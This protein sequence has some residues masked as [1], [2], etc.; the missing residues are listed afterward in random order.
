MLGTI[1]SAKDG[2]QKTMAINIGGSEQIVTG[3]AGSGWL[4]RSRVRRPA[5]CFSCAPVARSSHVARLRHRPQGSVISGR[6]AR[7]R[8]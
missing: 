3:Q 4:V 5:S 8:P 1:A 6:H 7:S 2:E